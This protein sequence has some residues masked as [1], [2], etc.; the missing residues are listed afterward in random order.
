MGMRLAPPS[1]SHRG[2]EPGARRPAH[3]VCSCSSPGAILS[4]RAPSA[5][6]S[7]IAAARFR[8]RRGTGR[9]DSANSL[10]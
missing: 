9:P 1:A 2:V 4:H 3:G 7:P 8:P 5:S 6:G 10:N